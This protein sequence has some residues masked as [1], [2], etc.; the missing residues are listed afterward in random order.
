[1][2]E[3]ARILIASDRQC[4]EGAYQLQIILSITVSM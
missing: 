3:Q 4:V 2:K 1:M